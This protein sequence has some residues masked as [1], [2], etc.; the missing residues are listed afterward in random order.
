VGKLYRV[1]SA[2]LLAEDMGPAAEA[3]RKLR[4][5]LARLVPRWLPAQAA[6]RE[7]LRGMVRSELSLGAFGDILTFALPLDPALKQELL[8]E[9]N[10][11]RRIRRLLAFLETNDPAEAEQPAQRQFPP[12]F[13]AN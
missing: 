2:D 3:A 9:L 13:S 5:K 7:Q 1:A 6:V 12:E 4:R 8:E 10:V 11:G